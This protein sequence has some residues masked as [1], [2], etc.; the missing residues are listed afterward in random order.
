MREKDFSLLKIPPSPNSLPRGKI[1]FFQFILKSIFMMQANLTLQRLPSALLYASQLLAF[2][3]I[4]KHK[5]S[6]GWVCAF[7][8]VE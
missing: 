2:S 8:S 1:T 3:F 5:K 4:R 7:V 6:L